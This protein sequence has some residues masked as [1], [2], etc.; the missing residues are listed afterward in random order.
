MKTQ[1]LTSAPQRTQVVAFDRGEEVMEALTTLARR[2]KWSA[3]RISGIGAFARATLG[4]FD[5]E[6]RDYLRIEID[7]QVE[8][9]TLLGNIALT[10]EGPKPHVHVVLGKRDGS[11]HGGHLLA[12]EVWPTLELMVVE[13]PRQL[14][15]R[16]DPE[17]Q[18][19]LLDPSA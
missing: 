4:Y 11:A 2:E 12:A 3:A 16:L 10:D 7:E 13:T 9:L 5:R 17:T 1:L 15:R 8:V 14:R 18:L 6:R 19:P